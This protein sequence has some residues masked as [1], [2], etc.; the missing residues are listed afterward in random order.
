[1]FGDLGYTNKKL[2]LKRMSEELDRHGNWKDAHTV[3]IKSG[4]MKV[5]Y[6]KKV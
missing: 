1:M 2:L 6:K 5:Y 4:I 3:F